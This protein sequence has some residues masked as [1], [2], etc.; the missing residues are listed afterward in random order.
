MVSSVSSHWWR[1]GEMY[2][3]HPILEA[4]KWPSAALVCV[5][6]A[7]CRAQWII[8]GELILSMV[9]RSW[10]KAYTAETSC[11][12]LLLLIY[13]YAQDQ[14][15]YY[16][17]VAMSPCDV[18]GPHQGQD[19]CSSLSSQTHHYGHVP[20][21]SLLYLCIRR[22]CWRAAEPLWCYVQTLKAL[23]I[24]VCVST[25]NV[26]CISFTTIIFN[27]KLLLSAPS[28]FVTPTVFQLHQGAGRRKT[29]Y[30]PLCSQPCRR[31]RRNTNSVSTIKLS[32]LTSRPMSPTCWLRTKSSKTDCLKFKYVLRKEGG[33]SFA[34]LQATGPCLQHGNKSEN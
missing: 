32:Q 7:A 28:I 10:W 31:W 15:A 24:C 29:C 6:C 1:W 22:I 14:F 23:F 20:S 21:L 12:Q 27:L 16:Q 8:T 19:C 4:S 5:C 25:V 33:R 18:H 30:F 13:V 2:V 11:N 9:V 17:Y 34:W 3:A 26:T